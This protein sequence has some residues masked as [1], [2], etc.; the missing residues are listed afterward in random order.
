MGWERGGR[1][2]AVHL[3]ELTLLCRKGR[4][5]VVATLHRCVGILQLHASIVSPAGESA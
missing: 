1:N 4:R 5:N 3:E 2:P